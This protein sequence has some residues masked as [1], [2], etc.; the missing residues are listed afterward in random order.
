MFD[1]HPNRVLWREG[2]LLGPTHMQQQERHLLNQIHT[3]FCAS[4]PYPWGFIR[5]SLDNQAL[6]S[7]E[8]GVRELEAILPDGLHLK[9]SDAA[10]L[11]EN[12]SFEQYFE[13]TRESLLVRIGVPLERPGIPSF[14]DES[15]EQEQKHRHTRFRVQTQE[16]YDLTLERERHE[17]LTAI[18]RCRIIFENEPTDAYVSMPIARLVRTKHGYQIDETFIAPSLCISAAP[19]LRLQLSGI[20]VAARKR[21]ETLRTKRRTHAYSGTTNEGDTSIYL[22]LF[23]I[24]SSTPELETLIETPSLCP[25]DLFLALYRFAGQLSVLVP[26]YPEVPKISYSHIDPQ[27]PFEAVFDLLYELLTY[28]FDDSYRRLPLTQRKDGLW[29]A[30]SKDDFLSLQGDF[31]LAIKF[32]TDPQHAAEGIVNLAKFSSFHQISDLIHS[33]LNGAGLRVLHRAPDELPYQENTI[34]LAIDQSSSHW[35]SIKRNSNLALYLSGPYQ[36]QIEGIDLLIGQKD[37]R[38]SI[39][40]A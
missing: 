2:V 36:Q 33:A 21:V 15:S 39:I 18:P 30:E 20:L 38:Q 37:S 6:T 31:V 24:A 35:E 11:P 29:I 25:Y 19:R 27:V 40:P 10:H 3:R 1:D 16:I 17:I 14:D 32:G 4:Q 9:C 5:L 34:Y 13:A 7:G 12:R 8:F 28:S 22:W 26:K 23:A